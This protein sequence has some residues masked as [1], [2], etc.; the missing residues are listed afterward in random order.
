MKKTILL[1]FAAAQ[2]ILSQPAYNPMTANGAKGISYFAHTLF[3]ENPNGVTYNEVYFNSDSSLVSVLDSNARIFNGFPNLSLDSIYLH[4]LGNLSDCSEYYWRVVEHYDTTYDAGETRW[5]R[6]GICLDTLTEDFENGLDNWTITTESGCGWQIFN[7]PVITG[8]YS[9][10]ST[11]G[12][13]IFAADA[14]NCGSG[15]GGSVSTAIFSQ[16]TLI[17]S[18]AIS[19]YIEW[20][21]DWNALNTLDSGFVDY[22]IDGGNTWINIVTYDVTDVRNT[23]EFFSF[24]P[25]PTGRNLKIRFRSVQPGWDWWWAVDNLSVMPN[26]LLTNSYPPALLKSKEVDSLSSIYLSWD[27]RLESGTGEF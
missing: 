14:D 5:F 27:T 9:L 21:N 13:G 7:D 24:N 6:T 2:I 26:V 10:P 22:S 1:I 25:S 19:Y 4:N 18:N 3:W 15:G 11:A 8:R 23:H 12:G 16:S 17:Q 20:D